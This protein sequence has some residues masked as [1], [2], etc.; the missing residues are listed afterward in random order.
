[1]NSTLS[2]WNF[3]HNQVYS[4]VITD[5]TDLQSDIDF[6]VDNSG[7][8]FVSSLDSL[9]NLNVYHKNSTA[10]N[11]TQTTLPKANGSIGSFQ[12][13]LA[14]HDDVVIAVKGSSNEYPLHTFNETWISHKATTPSTN[15]YSMW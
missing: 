5:M 3:D 2:V 1:M 9:G 11:W 7:T 15:G 10:T 4:S 8:M 14:V 6:A 12:A 13:D